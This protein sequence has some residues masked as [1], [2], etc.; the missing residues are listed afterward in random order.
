VARNNSSRHIGR[1]KRQREQTRGIAT[2][3]LAAALVGWGMV[4][5]PQSVASV[6][7]RA[8]RISLAERP[9]T[10][11]RVTLTTPVTLQGTGSGT[12]LGSIQALARLADGRYALVSHA[13]AAVIAV[14]AADGRFLRTV[15]RRGTGPGEF[16]YLTHLA[17][18]G[19]TLFAFDAR[20]RRVTAL[21]AQFAVARSAPFPGEIY[22]GTLPLN[23]SLLV[24]N[25]LVRTR[26]LVGFLAHTVDWNGGIVKSFASTDAGFRFDL[27]R[28]VY[29]RSFARSADGGIWIAPSTSYSLELWT[30]A[31]SLRR[32]LVRNANWFRD[33]LGTDGGLPT[34][35]HPPAPR[36]LAVRTDAQ[37]RIWTLTR[38][39]ATGWREALRATVQRN[40]RTTHEIVDWDR[41][42]D[43]IVEVI[44]PDD[45]AVLSST[46]FSE[47]LS[48]F[49]GEDGV[50]MITADRDG[51]TTVQ[52]WQLRF[53]DSTRRNHQ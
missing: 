41:A 16:S 15:G 27:D 18:H 22:W 30:P 19:S 9:C 37:G 48:H 35:D 46:R 52:S 20:Q 13:D 31:G 49:V 25:T 32:V 24:L 38:I 39:A 5:I 44:S 40:G 12:D 29:F 17:T 33:H 50:V 1:V 21:D 53:N 7:V 51:F 10:T 28:S 11:C 6:Q 14:F 43:S 34:P 2:R 45:A 47:P 42:F 3:R 4:A 26:E 36:L 23:D 8:E